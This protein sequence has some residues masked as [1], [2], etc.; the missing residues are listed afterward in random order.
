MSINYIGLPYPQRYPQYA[1]V[2]R[3][4]ANRP[5]L[6]QREATRLGSHHIVRYSLARSL[7]LLNSIR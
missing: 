5:L 4:P 6:S 2:K 1:L 7:I 3:L